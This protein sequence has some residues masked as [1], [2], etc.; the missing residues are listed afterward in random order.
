[1]CPVRNGVQRLRSNAYLV[2]RSATC[3]LRTP[4]PAP[5]RDLLDTLLVRGLTV[6]LPLH[7]ITVTLPSRYRDLLDILLVRSLTPAVPP[8]AILTRV[9]LRTRRHRRAHER[10]WHHLHDRRRVTTDGSWTGEAQCVR[11]RRKKPLHGGYMAVTWRSHGGYMAVTWWNEERDRRR[12]LRRR[13]LHVGVDK[14]K[15]ASA[16]NASARG[17]LRAEW[18]A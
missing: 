10:R 7:Y 11:M 6:T 8:V 18:R 17:L 13:W 15:E 12:P 14:W 2:E 16:E 9:T 5:H 3:Y 1:M 4:A